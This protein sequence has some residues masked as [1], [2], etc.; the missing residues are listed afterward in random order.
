MQKHKKSLELS[1]YILGAGAFGVFLRWLQNQLGF[2]EA[3]LADRSI[4]HI[5]V[6]LFIIAVA[7]VFIRFVD[8]FKAK[9]FYLPE[10]F[11]PALRNDGKFF[12]FLRWTFGL[13]MCLGAVM[14]FTK[15]E[16][17][18]SPVFIRLLAVLAFLTGIT[19]PVIL[20]AANHK[21][22]NPGWLTV[23][24]ILP[25]LM[26][27]VWLI[28]CYRANAINSVVWSFSIEIVAVVSAMLAFFRIAG[29]AFE[30]P[31]AGRSMFCCMFGSAMC[32]MAIADE[33]YMG[34]QLILFSAACMLVLY[35]WIMVMNLRQGRPQSE[36]TPEDGFE[37]L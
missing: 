22:D 15:A 33:R 3:G 11:G 21:P 6:P 23:L 26:F 19:F 1:C 13:I 36:V 28:S 9:R 29:F 24:C 37:R 5:L 27:S 35:N 25:V 32:F 16:T 18:P 12:S 30:T 2:D 7:V 14:L 34:M 8:K 4:F 20:T 17:D 31:N 10:G